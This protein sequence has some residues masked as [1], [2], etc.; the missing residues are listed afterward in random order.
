MLGRLRYLDGENCG[1]STII[2]SA[3]GSTVIV[4]DLPRGTVESGCRIELREGCDNRS[5]T[6]VSRFANA[7]NFRGEPHLAG[8]ALLTRYP[9]A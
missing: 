7:V 5:A 3:T 9:G 8:N 4:R 6:C 1:V 2:L